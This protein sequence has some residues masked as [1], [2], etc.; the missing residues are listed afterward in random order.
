MLSDP[1]GTADKIRRA[2]S[3]PVSNAQHSNL[4]STLLAG[5]LPR[6]LGLR[7]PRLLA[8]GL[9]FA[10]M[11]LYLA[12]AVGIPQSGFFAIFLTA[13][14]LTG[15]FNQLLDENRDEIY[16]RATPSLRVNTVT[17]LSVLM[18]FLGIFAAFSAAALWWGEDRLRDAFGFALDSANLG[19]DS[20]LTHSFSGLGG[21]LRHNYVVLA[22]FFA[23]AF[24]YRAYGALLALSWNACVWAMVLT[25]LVWRGL[26]ATTIA[27]ALYL[28]AA[29]LAVLP[30]LLIEAASYVLG[31]LAAI[32]CSKALLTYRVSEPRFW[33]VM[34]AVA[35]LLAAAALG[36]ALGALVETTLPRAALSRL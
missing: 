3:R 4:F 30:H 13:A 36:I 6:Q 27:P 35:L 8:E 32:F 18:L 22:T 31:A 2:L 14:G 33:R 16:Q 17:A 34:R 26:A 23:L 21:M 28:P 12:N 15:R 10:A 19:T 11:G 7:A 20:V 1:L 29:A 5:E 24:V 9:L 25:I